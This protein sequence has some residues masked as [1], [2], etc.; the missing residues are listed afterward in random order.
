[1]VVNTA[2]RTEFKAIAWVAG[3]LWGLAVSCSPQ[4][5]LESGAGPRPQSEPA[6]RP[7]LSSLLPHSPAT[8]RHGHRVH[9]LGQTLLLFGGFSHHNQSGTDET[10]S[11][12]WKQQKWTQEAP[13]LRKRAFFGSVT[14]N[15]TIYA[16]GQ[17]LER[18]DPKGRRWHAVVDELR[19]PKNH[20]GAAAV[21]SKIYTV[22]GYPT[23]FGAFLAYDTKTR[24][25]E[26]VPPLPQYQPGDHFHFVF[27]VAD[28]LHV[29]GGLV[30]STPSRIHYRFDPKTQRWESA[31][32]PPRPTWAKFASWG[33]VDGTLF[34]FDEQGSLEYHTKSKQWKQSETVLKPF[35]SMPGCFA[36]ENALYVTGGHEAKGANEVRIYDPEQGRWL[37]RP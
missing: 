3:C 36:R 27:A 7:E 32:S 20:F 15:G 26:T 2:R 31:P 22:G 19:F 34:I 17:T 16:I 18:W 8:A 30:E 6:S 24:T 33:I 37:S 10:W 28:H 13:L 35:Q 1:M 5:S 23:E 9:D 12:D 4:L 25:F 11:F 21:G 14:V 29:L